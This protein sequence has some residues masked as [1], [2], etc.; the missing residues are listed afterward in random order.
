[1][2]ITARLCC[3]IDTSV[4]GDLMNRIERQQKIKI[5]PALAEAF[6]IEHQ[7]PPPRPLIETR[8]CDC[9]W[10][11]SEG[12]YCGHAT[13]RGSYCAHHAPLVYEAH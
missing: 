8:R 3:S 2:P 1:M 4:R 7:T 6:L 5:T 13:V 11:V 10:L 9:R 12:V